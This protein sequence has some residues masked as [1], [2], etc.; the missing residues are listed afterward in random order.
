MI[1]RATFIFPLLFIILFANCSTTSDTERA[2]NLV[3]RAQQLVHDGNWRQARIILDSVHSIYPKEIAQRRLAMALE[4]SIVYLEAQVTFAYADSMLP[5][6][7]EKTDALIKLFR[8]EKDE[9]YEDYGRYV[10]RLLTTRENTSRNFLQV[11]VKDNRE[12]VV[13][14][15]YFGSYSV[16]QQQITLTSNGEEVHFAGNNHGFESDG[17]HEIMTIEGESALQL[18]NFISSHINDR[19]RVQGKGTKD[20]HTWVYYLTKQ[21]KQA[22]SDTYQ[23]GWLMKDIKHIEDIQR[24]AR[25]QIDRYQQTH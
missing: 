25:R 13:R 6:L 24:T 14:S 7:I 10:H 2:Q 23:L 12:I 19:I 16:Q 8:Y 4:D 15:Y 21:E 20:T 22:L 1:M 18:L 9:K 3:N 5:P 11:Y 17:W